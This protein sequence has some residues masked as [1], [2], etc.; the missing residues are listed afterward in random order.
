MQEAIAQNWSTRALERQINSFYYERIVSSKKKKSVIAE[1]RKKTKD[2]PAS[3]ED[4]IKDPY[5]LE[6]LSLPSETGFL[7]KD[8]ENAIIQKLQHFLLELGKVFPL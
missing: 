8:L 3:P 5:V 4:F 2:L 6:F 1:A 7:G